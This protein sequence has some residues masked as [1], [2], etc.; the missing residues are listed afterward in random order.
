VSKIVR[1]VSADTM[2]R[3]TETEVHE[4]GDG[5]AWELLAKLILSTVAQVQMRQKVHALSQALRGGSELT[6][7]PQGIIGASP[8]PDIL[9][10]NST[11]LSGKSIA[12]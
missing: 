2:D 3:V 10:V 9:R 1:L 6:G 11:S 5:K 8:S 4:C 12:D 7:V